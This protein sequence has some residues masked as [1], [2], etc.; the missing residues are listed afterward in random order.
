L[1]LDKKQHSQNWSR[2]QRIRRRASF[3]RIQRFGKK[4]ASKSFTVLYSANDT[5]AARFGLTVSKRVGTAVVRNR[6]KRR[7][8]E[9]LRRRKS[10]VTAVDLVIIAKPS[11]ASL[12][13]ESLDKEMASIL[14]RL[15][16]DGACRSYRKKA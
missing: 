12:D 3:R 11:A 7:L 16:R 1:D 4:I 8:R 5:N 9:S 13:Y 14:E 15:G 2:A 6:L 10:A